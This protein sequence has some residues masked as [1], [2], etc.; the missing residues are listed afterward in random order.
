MVIFMRK[1]I[2]LFSIFGSILTIIIIFIL[3][4]QFPSRYIRKDV[5]YFN[6]KI[7]NNDKYLYAIEYYNFI[8]LSSFNDEIIEFLYISTKQTAA[9]SLIHNYADYSMSYVITIDNDYEVL[10]DYYL[11]KLNF[12]DIYISN[13]KSDY[14]MS[15]VSMNGW[16]FK[17]VFFNL[18]NYSNDIYS[19]YYRSETCWFGYN[20]T[21]KKIQFSF[22]QKNDVSYGLLPYCNENMI[23]S[24]LKENLYV[25]KN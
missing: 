19:L 17:E 25:K 13:K 1:K 4:I 24:L 12:I 15:D 10:R 20:N 9:L 22:I 16:I 5:K 8:D 2:I 14:F 3:V 11:S 23:T 7:L 6:D 18:T 21:T